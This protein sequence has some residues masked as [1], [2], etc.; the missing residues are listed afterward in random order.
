[1]ENKSKTK[2][3]DHIQLK[4]FCTAKENYQQ[5][6]KGRVLNGRGYLQTIHSKSG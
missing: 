3:I 5:I 2:Q 1:M 4:T 6:E